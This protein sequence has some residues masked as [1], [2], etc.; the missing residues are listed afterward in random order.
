MEIILYF[1]TY[2]FIAIICAILF[3]LCGINEDLSI[4]LGI[5][6]FISIPAVICTGI[7]HRLIYKPIQF[8]L[9]KF[10]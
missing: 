8:I 9:R 4:I 10:I 6:W 7:C 2:L 1:V 3:K 5:L